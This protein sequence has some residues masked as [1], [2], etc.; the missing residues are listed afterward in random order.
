[1]KK[2]YMNID[3]KVQKIVFKCKNEVICIINKK[4][5]CPVKNTSHN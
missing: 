1:M 4:E 2:F 3:V 5:I